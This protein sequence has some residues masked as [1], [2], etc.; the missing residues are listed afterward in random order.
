MFRRE[1][2]R[3]MQ[4]IL[5]ALDPAVLEAR[6]FALGGA[7]RIALAHGEVRES[8]DLDF[9]GSDARGFA[10]LRA[11]V[12]AHGYAALF[13]D[14]TTLELPREPRSDQYGIRFPVRAG[15]RTIR[16]EFIHEGRITLGRPVREPFCALPCLS[17]EDCFAE[18]LLAS[19]DRGGDTAELDRDIVDLA[20]L[21]EVHG[22]IHPAAWAS[23]ERAYGG[24]V[25][26][27]LT[28]CIQRFRTDAARRGRAFRGLRVDD[29]ERVLRG[30]EALA[31][32][33][34]LGPPTPDE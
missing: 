29:P 27:D 5:D 21:R 33:L 25:R 34:G 32:D 31:A 24:S 17:I 22:P 8:G 19:S 12:R 13:R 16:V 18:K 15:E 3:A 6:G 2:H 26:T 4:A 9:I 10:D 30:I 7:T 1:I 23:A 11:A 28:A 20:V 14:T